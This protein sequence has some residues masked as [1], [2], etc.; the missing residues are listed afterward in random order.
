MRREA[1]EAEFARVMHVFAGAMAYRMFTARMPKHERRAL[2]YRN[3]AAR[4]SSLHYCAGVLWEIRADAA[5]RGIGPDA[6]R[7]KSAWRLTGEYGLWRH[8]RR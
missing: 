3:R 4:T 6:L 5:E 2:K 1:A 8:P 7:G